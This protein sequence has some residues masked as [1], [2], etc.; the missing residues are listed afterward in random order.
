MPLQRG[1]SLPVLFPGSSQTAKNSSGLDNGMEPSSSHM[2]MIGIWQMNSDLPDSLDR[3]MAGEMFLRRTCQSSPSMQPRPKEKMDTLSGMGYK[4]P[5]YQRLMVD[6]KRVALLHTQADGDIRAFRAALR[7][8]QLHIGLDDPT[9]KRMRELLKEADWAVRVCGQEPSMSKLAVVV[10]RLNE[11]DLGPRKWEN[12][13]LAS[14]RAKLAAFRASGLQSE[15]EEQRVRACDLLRS[16]GEAA[17]QHASDVCKCFADS[18][19]DVREAA[20]KCIQRMGQ[21]GAVVCVECLTNPNPTSRKIACETL[22]A[23]TEGIVHVAAV[24]DALQDAE[25]DVRKSA[26]L[27]FEAFG[28]N[29]AIYADNVAA[30]LEDADAVIRRIACQALAAI[31]TGALKHA[32]AVAEHL[33]RDADQSVRAAARSACQRFAALGWTGYVPA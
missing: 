23:M 15:D 27:A 28:P 3:V 21:G 19:F 8:A 13:T 22:G 11:L 30:G 1:G 25:V 18:S 16:M 10:R 32:G 29:G 4:G 9:V 33:E 5:L 7:A 24:A 20:S 31:G 6:D 17:A 12:P 2:S 14:S 26:F